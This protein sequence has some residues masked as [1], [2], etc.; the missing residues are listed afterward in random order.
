[1]VAAAS[2]LL[3]L[4][5]AVA[6]VSGCGAGTLLPRQTL[7]VRLVPSDNL[8]WL[9]DDYRHSQTWDPLLQAFRR[10]HPDVDVQISMAAETPL[11]A[12][13]QRDNSRGLGPDLLLVRA[14]MANALLDHGLVKP[15]PRGR[16][17]AQALALL[18]PDDLRR[19]T[20]RRGLAGLP[21]FNEVTL[22]CYDRRRL[23]QPPATLNE[24]LA[25]AA[26]GQ[27]VGLAV[28]PVGIWWTAGA[29]GAQ[30]LLEPVLT[31]QGRAAGGSREALQGWLGWLR[32]AA[33]QSQ[34]DVASNQQELAEGLESGRLAWAPCYSLTL[35]RLDRTMGPNLGVA[36]LP[37]GPAGGP[38]PFNALRVVALGVNSSPRQRQLALELA[39]LS[40]NP[41]VQR[42]ITLQSMMV[43]PTN[44]YVS[45]P[46]A[47]SGRL[48]A[49]AAAQAQFTDSST[50]LSQPFSADRVRGVQPAIEAIVSE[51][52]NGMQ[53]P[54]QGTAALLELSR[55]KP[56]AP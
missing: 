7:H 51:V 11:E 17:L 54:E 56:W 37:N 2:R 15:L 39:A 34:V 48:A 43:L 27:T 5:G 1:M 18:K 50:Q 45:V 55:R 12:S 16:Q 32:Q 44:R 24:L 41:L 9:Q 38:S 8:A 14:S 4:L 13:L 6:M 25:L 42:D 23:Q 47:S 22:A 26:S 49:L 3:A 19:V 35:H 21:V 28:D 33:L 31:G 20:H 40:L 10:L 30:D 36:P 53:T 46:V 29:L 52:M